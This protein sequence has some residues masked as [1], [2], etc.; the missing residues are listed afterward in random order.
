MTNPADMPEFVA[1]EE[2][3]GRFR[4]AV[5]EFADCITARNYGRAA[6]CGQTLEYFARL[7][8]RRAGD[9]HEAICDDCGAPAFS[10]RDTPGS[11]F[12]EVMP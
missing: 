11:D 5:S 3:V 12:P 8:A 7:S 4:D 6:D 2:A 9:L 1:L 10:R